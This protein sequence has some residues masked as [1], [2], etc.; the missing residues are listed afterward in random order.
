MDD[1]KSFSEKLVDEY[2]LMLLN[3]AYKKLGSREKAEELVQ[4]VW[5]AVFS[6]MKKSETSGETI[7]KPEN[8]IWKT[9]RFV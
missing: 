3:W 7:H 5:L 4:N 9:A 1:I 2:S 8:F 6:A